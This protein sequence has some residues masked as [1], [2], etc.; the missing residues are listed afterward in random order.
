MQTFLPYP[1]FYESLKTLDKSRLGNQI[2]REGLTLIRGGWKNHPAYKMW[3]DYK[4]ALAMYI[5]VGLDVLKERGKGYEHHREELLDYLVFPIVYPPWIGDER[6][7]ASH[8][9]NLLRKDPVWYGQ[10]QWKEP[11]DIPYFWPVNK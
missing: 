5:W 7:H 9:S 11:N 8:R 6:V 1:N 10:F 4:P 2:Y 3:R